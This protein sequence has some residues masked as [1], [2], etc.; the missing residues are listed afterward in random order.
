MIQLTNT[1]GTSSGVSSPKNY[2]HF[3]KLISIKQKIH[4]YDD[5]VEK[6]TKLEKENQLKLEKVQQKWLDY[7]L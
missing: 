1:Q 3:R 4:E 5:L 2:F 6:R 7:E